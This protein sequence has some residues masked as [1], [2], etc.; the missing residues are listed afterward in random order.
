MTNPVPNNYS[1]IVRTARR[2]RGWTQ[3]EL[4]QQISVTNVT[5]SRWE[6]GRV[7]PSAVLWERFLEI[8]DNR[9]KPTSA[10]S[11]P[12]HPPTVDFLGEG[13]AVRAMIEGERLAYG[14][15]ANPAFRD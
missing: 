15:L 8:A 7:E 9:S 6:K 12:D 14:H 1:E 2:A 11:G 3:A 5:I 4:A 10:P 13:L